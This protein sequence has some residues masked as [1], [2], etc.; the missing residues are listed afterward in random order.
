[1]SI[2][3]RF[4][5]S[6]GK[7]IWEVVDD[8]VV[9]DG[10]EHEDVGLRCFDFNL[11]DEERDGCVGDD[12]K[13]LPYLLMIMKLLNGDWEE[14]I[15]PMNKKVDKD[16]ERRGN[17][18]NGRFQKLRRFSRNE[19]WENIGCLLSEPTFG[20]GGSIMGQ[21]DLKISGKKRK[22]SLIRPKVDLYEVFASLFQII[23]Y[24]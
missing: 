8:H 4:L 13:L 12:V 9:E 2:Q 14:H 20:L 5:T 15:D 18:D 22:R 19:F 10:V 7:V 6:T 11:F 23:Y 17:Q 1:M 16:N 3:L 21:N 24:C